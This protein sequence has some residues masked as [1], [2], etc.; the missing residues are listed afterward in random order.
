[1]RFLII[2]LSALTLGGCANTPL[3]NL[4]NNQRFQ[5]TDDVQAS[6]VGSSLD[7][8]IMSWGTPQNSFP[9][10]GVAASMI[11][12]EYVWLAGASG[13]NPRYSRCVQR[14]L[15]EGGIITKWGI[16]GGCPKQPKN[17]KSIPDTP[18]PK[19]TL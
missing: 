11:S 16:S 4:L 2:V 12:Y 9:M 14:F 19:P 15:V 7:D 17:A 3:G 13:D 18:V 10:A 6:W 8:L 1:M 5:T